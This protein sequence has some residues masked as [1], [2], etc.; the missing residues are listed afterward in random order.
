MTQVH[1]ELY[2]AEATIGQLGWPKGLSAER[3]TASL[4]ACAARAGLHDPAERILARVFE[5][6]EFP[7][8]ATRDDRLAVARFALCRLAAR[9]DRPDD[10]RFDGCLVTDEV[11]ASD[12][13]SAP[14]PRLPSVRGLHSAN[15]KG[16]E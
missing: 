3:L 4:F 2:D 1:G 8:F 7:A 15:A 13:W 9:L 5:R 12:E 16:A 6:T 11:V 14:S 10:L